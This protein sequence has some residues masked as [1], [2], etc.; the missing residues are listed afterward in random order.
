MNYP[1]IL[2]FIERTS[3][4]EGRQSRDVI[5][6]IND[7]RNLRDDI[8]RLLLDLQSVNKQPVSKSD[9]TVIVQMIGEKWN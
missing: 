3:A 4:A 7:A 1:H 2:K 9:E 8:A 6:A 5:L